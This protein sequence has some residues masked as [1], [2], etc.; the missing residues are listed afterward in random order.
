MDGVNKKGFP[1]CGKDRFGL[2]LMQKATQAAT[3]ND[4][5]FIFKEYIYFFKSFF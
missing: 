3:N 5:I 1:F 4:Q 2:Y